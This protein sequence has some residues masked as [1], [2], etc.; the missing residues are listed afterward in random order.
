MKKIVL[1]LILL[2]PTYYAHG[3]VNDPYRTP[4][5]PI[6]QSAQITWAPQRLN[7]GGLPPIHG[8]FGPHRLNFEGAIA[9][10]PPAG[11][12]TPPGGE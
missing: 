4:P 5:R 10:V 11:G 8:D 2:S 3:A 7:E 6:T 12:T 9:A 1:G